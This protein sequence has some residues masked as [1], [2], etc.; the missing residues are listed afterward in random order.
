M[1][2]IEELYDRLAAAVQLKGDDAAIRIQAEYEPQAGPSAK[3]FPPTYA[4]PEGNTPP[5]YHL[6]TRWGGDGEPVD[7]VLLDSYQSQANRVE[8]ALKAN[9]EDLGLP[10]LVVETQADGHSVRISSLDAP[11][12]SRDAY[13]LDSEID[14]VAFDKTEVGKALNTAT[15]DDATAYLRFAPY[16]LVYGVWDSHRGKRIAIKFA[17]AFT[18]EMIGWD[19]L[20]GKR[21]ATKGDPLNLTKTTHEYSEWRPDAQTGE[22]GKKVE[23]S[24]IGHGMIPGSPEESTGGVSVRS[25]SRIAVLS[26]TALAR[27][28]FPTGGVDATIEGRTV[29]AAL[30]LVGDRLAF[31]GAGINLRSGS[32]LV[33]ASERIEWVRRANEPELFEMA[34]A[35]ALSL[36]ELAQTRLVSVGIDWAS[37]PVLLQPNDRLAALIDETFAV[38]ELDAKD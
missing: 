27:F 9:A 28:T 29:L 6:E 37:E 12:R 3:V 34:T 31:G 32:D 11:H 14:G 21:S 16:D 1:T 15:A 22:I 8:A 18:S 7:V 19:V 24:K 26:L 4:A 35:D 10:Q 17:R 36:L 13:F 38:P 30:A 23:T 25:I 33:L 5:L 2:A 20:R